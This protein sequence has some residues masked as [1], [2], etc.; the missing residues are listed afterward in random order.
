MELVAFA[1]VCECIAA[2][3]P[4]VRLRLCHLGLRHP[5]SFPTDSV[6]LSPGNRRRSR[7]KSCISSAGWSVYY[8]NRVR[9]WQR[10]RW[11][12]AAS[13]GGEREWIEER[14]REQLGTERCWRRRRCHGGHG[15]P[16]CLHCD[17]SVSPVHM[18]VCQVADQKTPKG[19]REKVTRQKR[20]GDS[21]LLM[22][23][24]FSCPL[25]HCPLRLHSPLPPLR[26]IPPLQISL[27]APVINVG[28][29]WPPNRGSFQLCHTGEMERRTVAKVDLTTRNTQ[30][31][32]GTHTRFGAQQAIKDL[33]TSQSPPDS[34]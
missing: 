21:M 10:G 34:H 19:K 2:K 23:A 30:H 33:V 8:Y 29:E 20:A 14:E 13:N 22:C 11:Q 16:V 26:S 4:F 31:R 27:T 28:W 5:L 32:K 18:Q 25:R 1:D 7:L 17:S 15:V 24:N 9:G 12:R 6:W 3:P